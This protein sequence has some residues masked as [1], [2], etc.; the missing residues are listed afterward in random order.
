MSSAL[1][2]AATA[3]VLQQLLQSGFSA[4]KLDDVLGATSVPVTCIPPERIAVESDSSQLNLFLYNQT[5]NTGWVNLGQPS[6]DGRGERTDNPALAL[7]LH[8]LISAYGTA[9]FHAEIMLGAAMQILH[10]TPVLGRAAIRDALKPGSSKPGLPKELELAGLADQL[11]QLRITPLNHTTDEVSRIWSA[12]Q[13]PARP[14]AAYMVSV[15]LVQSQRSQRTPL[16]V[17]AR[18]LCVVP[19]R[20]PRLDRVESTAGA[21]APILPSGTVKVSGAN[22]AAQSLSLL[23][24]GRE[25]ASGVLSL[26][27]DELTFGFVLP[28]PPGIPDTLRAGVCTLQLVHQQLLGSPPQPHGGQESNLA[29]FVLNPEVAFSVQPGASSTLVDGITYRSGAIKAVCTPRIGSRQRVRLLLNEKN[30][31]ADRPARAYSFT[32]SDG[33]GIVAP[34]DSTAEVIIEYSH[35][36]QGSYLARLQVD[37]GTSPLVVGADG[38]FSGPELQP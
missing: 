4:L 27:G 37:A 6:R 2:I 11:E 7:D 21:S 24:N 14:S 8:F 23:V 31:P 36:A 13:T 25:F 16:P 18:N 10:D 3:A 5:R 19:L 26:A 33:N 32:A 22:L 35:V 1:G 30:P 38:R 12:L 20:A 17:L 9:D 28:A 29:A 34:A 15:L